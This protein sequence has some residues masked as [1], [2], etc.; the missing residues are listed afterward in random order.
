MFCL[1]PSSSR[2]LLLFSTPFTSVKWQELGLEDGSVVNA[3][4][5]QP[6]GPWWGMVGVGMSW[7]WQEDSRRLLT[8]SDIL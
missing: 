2:Y 1:L 4:V 8:Y 7:Q 5:R 3:L 6:G